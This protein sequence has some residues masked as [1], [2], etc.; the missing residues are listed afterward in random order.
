MLI[1]HATIRRSRLGV[2]PFPRGEYDPSVTDYAWNDDKRDLVHYD[3]L[4][5]AVKKFDPYGYVPKGSVPAAGSEYWELVSQFSVLFAGM[6]LAEHIA[7]GAITADKLAADAISVTSA[8]IADAIIKESL[9]VGK[10]F[11]VDKTGNVT[12]RNADVSGAIKSSEGTLRAQLDPSSGMLWLIADNN[13]VGRFGF[14]DGLPMVDLQVPG[15]LST[16][17]VRISNKYIR[18]QNT[19]LSKDIIISPDNFALAG[20]LYCASD[21]VVRVRSGSVT[22]YTLTLIV[23]QGK[24]TLSG[25]GD[26]EYGATPEIKAVPDAGYSFSKWSDNNTSAIRTVTITAD[27]TLSAY[28]TIK[29]YTVALAVSPEGAGTV[30]GGGTK[31]AGTVAEIRASANAGYAFSEWSDGNASAIRE[32][33]WDGD[34]TL[35]AFFTAVATEERYV[36]R[37]PADNVSLSVMNTTLQFAVIFPATL[38]FVSY[39]GRLTVKMSSQD[40]GV[41]TYF[42]FIL[43]SGV[44]VVGYAQNGILRSFQLETHVASGQRTELVLSNLQWTSGVT[45]KVNGSENRTVSEYTEQDWPYED[46]ADN[47]LIVEGQGDVA[48]VGI[49]FFTQELSVSDTSITFGSIKFTASD[50]S[51]ISNFISLEQIPQ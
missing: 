20:E 4:W 51:D 37:M 17:R 50:S 44:A 12:L 25:G 7:A 40:S 11:M 26:Y 47:T 19:L 45:F 5:W 14:I 23:A 32:V 3:S 41:K 31:D 1:S 28:F 38:D 21:G 46:F 42:L 49:K 27:K 18:V 24:G 39:G 13:I 22:K 6:I 36:V 48:L 8:M 35:T 15:D 16:Y 33:I 43:T 2:M 10:G 34:K 29:Q 9:S 30:S